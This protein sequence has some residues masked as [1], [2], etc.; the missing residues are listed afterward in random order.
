MSAN[1]EEAVPTGTTQTEG[2]SQIDQSATAAENEGKAPEGQQQGKT[3]EGEDRDGKGRFRSPAQPR[4]DELTRARR[5]AERERDYWRQRAEAGQPK[6]EAAKPP[7]KP[8]ADQFDDYGQYIEALTDWKAEQKAREVVD[9]RE[10]ETAQKREVETRA[11]TFQERQAKAREAMADYDDVVAN[12]DTPVAE[13]VSELLLDSEMGPQLAYHLAKNPDVAE[14]L[15]GMNPTQAAREIGRLE[16]QLEKPAPSPT[17]SDSDE[18]KPPA[19]AAPAAQPAPR[20]RTT[21]APPPVKPVTNSGR[22]GPVDLAK[23]SGDD[24]VAARKAQGARWA[25]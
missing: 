22:S 24:Y 9:S 3:N 25:R 8:T 17:T 12:S 23:L 10:K 1:A 5:D 13:H 11:N 4:I 18:G 19:N 14:R 15:N 16:V 7:A 2:D 21:N 6:E 20:P